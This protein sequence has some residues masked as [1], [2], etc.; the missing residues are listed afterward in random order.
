M[1]S[2]LKTSR[3]L[4][5]DPGTQ[6]MG[7]ALL[8]GDVVVD[9]GVRTLPYG[10]MVHDLLLEAEAVLD[11][12]LARYRPDLF[13]IEHTFYIKTRRGAILR[14]MVS[15]L[16]RLAR[17]RGVRVV[18]YMPTAVKKAVAGHGHASKGEVAATLTRRWPALERYRA[19][20]E[21]RN[22][23]HWQHMFDA[24]ALAL[25]ANTRRH[26]IFKVDEHTNSTTSS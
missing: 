11:E 4:G 20:G 21:E 16:K 23:T 17:D 3:I 18:S 6:E 26:L 13:V 5:L 8:E 19:G 7:Y 24:L 12:L 2:T 9:F 10:L 1:D 14:I 25:T 22:Q 15:E